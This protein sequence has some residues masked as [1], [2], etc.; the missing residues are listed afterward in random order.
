MLLKIGFKKAFKNK[1]KLV[2]SGRLR[3]TICTQ[4]EIEN[5]G[6]TVGVGVSCSN[7]GL[8]TTFPP[9]LCSFPLQQNLC[10]NVFILQSWYFTPGFLQFNLSS[11]VFC[12]F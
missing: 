2:L 7:P 5:I 8:N 4:A 6:V 11:T 3:E 12:P 10:S 1:D 9:Q